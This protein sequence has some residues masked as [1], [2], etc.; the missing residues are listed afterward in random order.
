MLAITH[1]TAIYARLS[2]DRSGLSENVNR[3][4]ADAQEFAD[5]Q[6]WPVAVVRSD[7]DTSASKFSNKPRPGYDQLIVDVRSNRVEVILVTEMTR[8]YRR[9]EELLELIKMAEHT[10]LRAIWTTDDEGFDLST[11]EGIHRAIGA[12]N[13]A[14][15]ESAKISKRSKVKKKGRA[16]KGEWNGGGR[17]YG[18][19]GPIYGPPNEYNRRE[20]LNLERKRFWGIAHVPKEVAV[21]QEVAGRYINGESWRDM[22]ADLN[23]RGIHT[24][25]GKQWRAQNL[26]ALMFK[27]RNIGIREH[28]GAEYKAAWEPILTMEQWD[29]MH[30]T[31]ERKAIKY[32]ANYKPGRKYLLT[33]FAY[34]GR[35]AGPMGGSSV[36]RDV[37]GTDVPDRKRR[38]RCDKDAG[39]CGKIFRAADPL[40]AW[41][42]E[43][44]LY[45]FDSPETARALRALDESDD[46]TEELLAEYQARKLK[47][48]ELVDDYAQGVLDKRDFARAKNLAEARLE[49]ARAALVKAQSAKNTGLLPVDQTIREAW[50]E[51]GFDWRRSVIGLLVERITILPNPGGAGSIKFKDWRFNPSAVEI[52]WL[53]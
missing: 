33:G 44:V 25:E 21:L 11:P 13:N 20:I 45:R 19:E 17:S 31:R 12:V 35:C 23:K 48:D 16:K 51:A 26:K 39:G 24:A 28:N 40:E 53:V 9:I 43:A 47:K 42:V 22:A 41:V 4:I 5:D 37:R 50:E 30:A 46:R 6:V 8:L 36:K 18:F 15:L 10:R 49:E 1:D 14:M 27:K 38:Y 34:C 2:R 3:Q 29:L 7:N 32:G 52:S